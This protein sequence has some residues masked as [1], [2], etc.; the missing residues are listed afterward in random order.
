MVPFCHKFKHVKNSLKVNIFLNFFGTCKEVRQ[1]AD[2]STTVISLI[3][4]QFVRRNLKS[5]AFLIVISLQKLLCSASTFDTFSIQLVDLKEWKQPIENYGS[6][7]QYM[8]SKIGFL[9]KQKQ[10]PWKMCNIFK[11]FSI[12]KIA[13]HFNRK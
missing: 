11:M 1:V 9:K 4:Q 7:H 2:V 13:F 3:S 8:F 12:F 10:R 6:I 5:V